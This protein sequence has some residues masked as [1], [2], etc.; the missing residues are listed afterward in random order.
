MG[1]SNQETVF[2]PNIAKLHAKLHGPYVFYAAQRPALLRALLCPLEIFQRSLST[3]AASRWP[4]QGCLFTRRG[5]RESRAG[6]FGR[7]PHLE[8]GGEPHVNQSFDGAR[9]VVGVQRRENQYPIKVIWIVV[10]AVFQ[11]RIS[12]TIINVRPLF[13][14][15]SQRRCEHLP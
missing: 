12:F 9:S 8:R 13:E 10:F 2:G 1:Q 7:C 11:P 3:I 5:R 14:K 6:Y 4:R 15:G